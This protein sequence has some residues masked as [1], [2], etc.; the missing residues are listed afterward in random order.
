MT[1][2]GIA[3]TYRSYQ[4]GVLFH[5]TY[6]LIS[7][8]VH[9]VGAPSSLA[10][11]YPRQL[12]G[13]SCRGLSCMSYLILSIVRRDGIFKASVTTT[14][15]TTILL[16]PTKNCCRRMA[17]VGGTY[18]FSGWEKAAANKNGYERSYRRSCC[19]R[20]SYDRYGGY[21]YWSG[22]ECRKFYCAPTRRATSSRAYK[23][24]SRSGRAG[25]RGQYLR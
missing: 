21:L 12:Q 20:T 25:S 4:I 14:T 5:S 6:P 18:T 9:T 13:C 7:I 10:S 17:V 24:R 11:K 16:C 2:I 23:V 22:R 1:P 8:L 15:T 19:V 3:A